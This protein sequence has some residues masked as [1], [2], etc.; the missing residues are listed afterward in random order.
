MDLATPQI[1]AWSTLPSS[2]RGRVLIVDDEPM[3]LRAMQRW[4]SG[5][6]DVTVT[7]SATEAHRLVA[8]GADY[9][10]ILCDLMMP[11]MTGMQ[12]HA[13]L[14]RAFPAH[15]ERMIFLTGG[16]F[17]PAVQVFLDGLTNTWLDKPVDGQALRVLI[18]R[19]VAS[20]S[21]P[22]GR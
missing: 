4:L 16:A 20:G 18:A 9:D 17:S 14:A 3:V 1:P 15:A 6:H 7:T 22:G 19:R 8:S 11:K 12:W 13:E 10:V 5:A 21:S 2:R